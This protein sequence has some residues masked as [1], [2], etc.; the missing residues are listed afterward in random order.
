MLAASWKPTLRVGIF[1]S[2]NQL[3]D[4]EEAYTEILEIRKA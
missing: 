1:A 2:K 3:S 4:C